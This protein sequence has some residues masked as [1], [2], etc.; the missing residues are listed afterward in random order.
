M[1]CTGCEGHV[2][3][4]LAGVG[5]KVVT[6]DYRRGEAR[7]RLS[8]GVDP[9][10]VEKAIKGISYEPGALE[11]L[12]PAVDGDAPRLGGEGQYDLVIIGSGGAA[13]SAAIQ[14][15]RYGARVA[16]IERGTMGGTCVNIGCVPSKTLLRA[17]EIYFNVR[18]NPFAGLGISAGPL[19]L[20]LLVGQKN[21]LVAE[22]RREKYEGLVEEYGFDVIRGEAQFIDQGS[23]RVGDQIVAG[24]AFLIATGASPGIPEIPGLREVSF[25][26]STTTLEQRS[27][28]RSLAVIGSGYIALELG[29]LYRHLGSR[30]T[31]M[32]RS[33]R[34]LKEYEPEISAAVTTA[35]ARQGIE[36]ITGAGYERIEEDRM[37]KR[38]FI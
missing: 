25:L 2:V 12:E 16:M 26:T 34:I 11:Y 36:L 10:V 6:A 7:F 18:N 14:A 22:L 9:A 24:K 38:V 35:L 17:G 19:D 4:A 37:G 1:T 32:Q 27:L 5:A 21:E 3:A 33:E 13:F 29:Q 23:V 30:V 31:L 28:P 20:G 8:A 15:R